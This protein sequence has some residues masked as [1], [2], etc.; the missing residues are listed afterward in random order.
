MCC[1][2]ERPWSDR[3]QQF[4]SKCVARRSVPGATGG[5]NLRSSKGKTR[6][7]D[8]VV[9]Y[10]K[11][12]TKILKYIMFKKRTEKEVFQKFSSSVEENMLEDIIEELKENGYINDKQYIKKAVT[13]YI[14]L[15]NLS[16]KELE[17]K[18]YSKGLNNDI[19]DEY[20]NEI[21][22]KLEEY[23]LQSAKNIILKKQQ[24]MNKEEIQEFLRK[25][26]Y[27]Q[28][29]IKQAFLND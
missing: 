27:K 22:E 16:I 8:L 4:R 12:K 15:Q 5:N 26:G 1:E 21:S 20:F 11:H 18:L 13:E 3:R 29:T 9:E 6:M 2:E 25:K 7:E 23:E 14:N 24:V 10:D 28:D 19:I 17:Y